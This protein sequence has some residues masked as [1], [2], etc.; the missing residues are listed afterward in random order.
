MGVDEKKL[1]KSF[2]TMLNE[3]DK[4]G[5]PKTAADR[6]ANNAKIEAA[7]KAALIRLAAKEAMVRGALTSAA[8][9]MVFD[10]KSLLDGDFTRYLIN[11]GISS[12]YGGAVEGFSTWID[13]PFFGNGMVLGVLIG[14]AFGAI[15]LAGTG[16]WARFGKDIGLNVAGA[17]ASWG[18]ASAGAWIGAA[19]GGP[20]SWLTS[21][22]FSIMG[23][24]SGGYFG[25]NMASKVPILGGKTDIE[26]TTV[27]EKI[28]Q[29]LSS[30]GLSRAGTRSIVVPKRSC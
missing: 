23:G 12:L 20:L 18:G 4:L 28:K 25:R 11:I 21:P 19:P 16:D 29:Q 24:I 9:T 2:D 1:L 6:S 3:A 14:S 10:I 5:I 27:Y 15:S 8:L 7:M 22:V 26:Y 13:H 30:A 17:T